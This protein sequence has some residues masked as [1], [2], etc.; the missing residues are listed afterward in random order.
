MSLFCFEAVVVME[1]VFIR[2]N[3][4]IVRPMNKNY[5]NP[6]T[7]TEVSKSRRQAPP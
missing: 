5:D 3:V 1:W 6:F 4:N 2:I 7:K